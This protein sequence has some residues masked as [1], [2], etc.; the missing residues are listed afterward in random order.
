MYCKNCGNII[1]DRMRYCNNCGTKIEDSIDTGEYKQPRTYEYYKNKIDL[2]T[3]DVN[4]IEHSKLLINGLGIG[5]YYPR[6]IESILAT[7]GY[8]PEVWIDVNSIFDEEFPKI[9]EELSGVTHR[10]LKLL[11]ENEILAK[12]KDVNEDYLTQEER[13]AIQKI[14]D[15]ID[16]N[17]HIEEHNLLIDKM[18]RIEMNIDK[19]GPRAEERHISK[20]RAEK[21]A[22]IISIVDTLLSIAYS[23]I[24]TVLIIKYSNAIEFVSQECFNSSEIFF[25]AIGVIIIIAF[26]LFFASAY[27]GCINL[28]S[29]WSPKIGIL[30]FITGAIGVVYGPLMLILSLWRGQM[31][32]ELG[33]SDSSMSDTKVY[34]E[35]QKLHAVRKFNGRR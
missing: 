10:Y 30:A 5:I 2:K 28:M 24:A 21:S 23:V 15:E 22:S 34:N 6:V 29:S 31:E 33:Y 18:Q 4:K 27:L 11:E 17:T 16:L 19:L 13:A 25:K 32:L 20:N 12:F 3:T 8:N 14:R 35:Y 9:K 26:I 1:E 7:H